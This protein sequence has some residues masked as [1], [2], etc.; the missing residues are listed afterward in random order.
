MLV[1]QLKDCPEFIAGDGSILRE[2]LHGDKMHLPLNYSLAY[3]KVPVGQKTSR[4]RLATSE[5]YYIISGSG[6][7][8][9]DKES[10]PVTQG[11]TVYIPPGSIQ[12]IV[13]TGHNNLE[14]LCIV[15]PAWKKSDEEILPGS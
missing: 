2:I 7:M 1:K 12:H 13:N 5:V 4:H 11:S 10:Q 6:L 3:A 14:F 15:C 9:I 8:H